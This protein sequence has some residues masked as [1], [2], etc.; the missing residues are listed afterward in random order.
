[1]ATRTNPRQSCAYDDDIEVFHAADG[2][3]VDG[4]CQLSEQN[5][6]QEE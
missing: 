4:W 2:N 1:M 5:D 3:R 6:N